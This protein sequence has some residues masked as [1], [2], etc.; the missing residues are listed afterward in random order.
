MKKLL[1]Q[2]D[3]YGLTDAVSKGILY[4]IEHGVIRN[5]G[6]FVNMEHAKDAAECI[7]NLDVCLGIDINLVAGKPISDPKLIPNL[8][9]ENGYF[10]SSRHQLKTN[11]VI[12]VEGVVTQFEQDPY[13]YDEVILETENQLKKFIEL[14]GKLPEYFH[15]HSLCTPNTEKAAKAIAEKYQI[16]WTADL[17]GNPKYKQLP[18]TISLSKDVSMEAQINQDVEKDVLEIALPTLKEGEIGYY[19]CHCGYVDY[20]LFVHSSLTLRRAKDLAAMISPKVKEYLIQ[21]EIELITY[22]DL[23]S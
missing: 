15:P 21:N 18:G 11:K 13:P 20:D 4:A 2:S 6:L 7:K 10:L 12:S 22:R 19:I 5:T 8:V 1:I 23:V 16:Y 3:D 14:T 9:D 17:M